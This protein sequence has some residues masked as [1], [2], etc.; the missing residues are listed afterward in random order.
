MQHH[1]NPSTDYLYKL[2][3]EL[4][5]SQIG[6]TAQP[7]HPAFISAPLDELQ[8]EASVVLYLST[9]YSAYIDK[10]RPVTTTHHIRY[11]I[12]DLWKF[13]EHFHLQTDIACATGLVP[14]PSIIT[15]NQQHLV[16][17]YDWVVPCTLFFYFSIFLF[18]S[19][20]H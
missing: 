11:D 17:C 4:A 19:Y 8:E 9:D 15:R 14:I 18:L 1:Y 20:K 3:Q 13:E 2:Q 6:Y 10:I 7:D 16:D 5:A 12:D